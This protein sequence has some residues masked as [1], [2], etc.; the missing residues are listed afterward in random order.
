MFEERKIT[1]LRGQNKNKPKYINDLRKSQYF[2]DS[3]IPRNRGCDD[4]KS[5]ETKETD[6]KCSLM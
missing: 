2:F 4:L 3:P 1:P 6:K 5:L